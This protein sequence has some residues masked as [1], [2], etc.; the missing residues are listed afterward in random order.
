MSFCISH[1]KT[2]RMFMKKIL[3]GLIVL[4]S[5]GCS[6]TLGNT[7]APS[8]LI[9]HMGSSTVAL[10]ATKGD[11]SRPYCTGV[12]VG[13]NTILTANHCVEAAYMMELEKKFDAMESD[14]QSAFKKKMEEM[15]HEEKRAL[16]VE[17]TVVRYIVEGDVDELGTAPYAIRIGK[18]LV[19]DPAHDLALV[20]AAGKNLPAHDVAVVAALSPAVGEKISVVG[21][22]KGLYWTYV[23]GTVGQYRNTVPEKRSPISEVNEIP[24]VGPYLQ[25]SA[26]V[27]YGNSGGGAF[28]SS[29]ELVGIASFLTGAPHS[30]YFIHADAIRN[31]LKEHKIQ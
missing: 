4:L 30:C 16:V 19:V 13:S 1:D 17:G 22:V 3:L 7:K 11:E 26:P 12:W 15:T 24:I 20:E 31:L 5:F 23:E 18:V 14:E 25:A 8:S 27:W 28:D 6:S 9:T 29:G 2:T 10:M 21:Q